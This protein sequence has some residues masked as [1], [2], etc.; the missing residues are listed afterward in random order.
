MRHWSQLATRN[1]RVKP[2]RSIAVVLAVAL[3]VGTVITVTSIYASVERTI[4]EQIVDNWLGKSHIS[5][6]SPVGHWGNVDQA[7]VAAVEPVEGVERV[8]ARLKTRMGLVLSDDAPFISREA[9]T[10]QS[11]RVAVDVVGID[12]ANEYHFRNFNSLTGNHIERSGSNEV[13]F[14]RRLAGDLG[15]SIGDEVL[16]EVYTGQQPQL[17]TVVG[18]IEARRV[19]LFQN[20]TVYMHLTDVQK[21]RSD[22]GKISVID[23]L[24]TNP[25]IETINTVAERIRKVIRDR[26]QGYI[27]TTASAK[28]NQLHEAQKATRLMLLLFAFVAMLTSFFIIITTMSMGMLERVRQLGTMRCVGMTR[29]QLAGL[30]YLEIVPL[31]ILGSLLGVPIGIWLIK[32]GI[33]IIPHVEQFAHDLVYSQWGIV[34]GMAGGLV[35]AALGATVVLFKGANVS[36]LRAVNPE[37]QEERTRTVI[38]AACVGCVFLYAHNYLVQDLDESLWL[39]PIFAFLATV[40]LDGGYVLIAPLLVLLVAAPAVNLVAPLMG[41]RRKL[42]QDQMG[43]A[44]WR[45]AGV[46]WTLMVGLSLIVF[47]SVRGESITR[48]WDFPARLAGT[49]VWSQNAVPRK[50]VDEVEQLPGVGETTPINDVRCKIRSKRQS[51]LSFLTS[52]SIFAAGDP[53]TF[54]SMAKLAFLQGNMEDAEAKLR[55]GGYVLLTPEASHSFGYDLG[56]KVPVTIADKTVE[57]EVAGVVRSPSMDIAVSYF[58]ADSYMMLASASSVLGT[59][60]DLK[61][62]FGIDAV[63]MFLMN[64]DLPESPYAD[65]FAEGEPPYGVD[66]R[67]IAGRLET[68][69]DNLPL[70]REFVLGI[71][72]DL[73]KWLDGHARVPS[74]KLR[75]VLYRYAQALAEVRHQ[76]VDLKPEARWE[77]FRERLVL[78]RVKEHMHRPQA[79]TGSLRRLK[80]DIDEDIRTGTLLVSSIPAISLLVATFGV[81]NLMMVNVTSRSR[82][83]ATMRAVGATKSQIARLVLCEAAVLGLLGSGVGVLLGL[84]S[85]YSTN[86]LTTRLIGIEIPWA[87]PWQRVLAAVILTW[88]VCLLAGIGPALRASRNNVIEALQTA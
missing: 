73:E 2:G 65:E 75:K 6:E 69:S 19:A 82:Q 48:A 44:P 8:A 25:E 16:F 66:Q 78:E 68:W 62:H 39:N 46:C 40:T 30:V 32:L 41:L 12:P 4:E 88:L 10:I 45:S 27:V 24:V 56:D 9:Y 53:E 59:I 1:W 55:R 15:I 54:L 74:G 81:A 18:L 11:G 14:E 87:V 5:V 60:D 80:Q 3:G 31:G 35:T 67:W 70:E 29:S 43:R 36:P 63:K 7:L 37:S 21:M 85:A 58:Q 57:F 23:V 38:L 72:Q 26:R 79:Q 20:P 84:H 49:F 51:I 28:L 86:A 47:F 22:Q 42:A 13:I 52:E 33:K 17:C 83:L 77:I 64:I 71:K 34:V 76:W 50:V 61:K